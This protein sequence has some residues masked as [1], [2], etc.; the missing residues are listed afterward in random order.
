ML[1]LHFH[2][3]GGGRKDTVFSPQYQFSVWHTVHCK[4]QTALMRAVVQ[5]LH[6]VSVT[7]LTRAA[8]SPSRGQCQRERGAGHVSHPLQLPPSPPPDPPCWGTIHGS[9]C[10]PCCNSLQ[11]SWGHCTHCCVY[12]TSRGGK[13]TLYDFTPRVAVGQGPR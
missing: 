11:L 6:P 12:T 8:P 3:G 7:R 10:K 13:M 9:L 4:K 1:P 5:L 2:E